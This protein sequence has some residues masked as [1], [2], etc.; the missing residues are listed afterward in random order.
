MLL[1]DILHDKVGTGIA[2]LARGR[3][4]QMWLLP[5]PSSGS[6]LSSCSLKIQ[7]TTHVKTSVLLKNKEH[8]MKRL[9]KEWKHESWTNSNG[10]KTHRTE[11]T[12]RI[13]QKKKKNE[14]RSLSNQT[15]M[16]K[17]SLLCLKSKIHTTIWHHCTC[18]T[19]C[20]ICSKK[21]REVAIGLKESSRPTNFE[22]TYSP[23]T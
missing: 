6:S 10:Y 19:N 3:R 21:L 9:V 8:K 20:L 5:P 1:V 7:K 14:H 16:H 13:C 4:G 17:V 22:P 18:V 12:P 23:V 15:K 2:S 11:P